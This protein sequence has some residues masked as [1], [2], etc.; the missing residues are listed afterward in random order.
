MAQTGTSVNIFSSAGQVRWGV[1]DSTNITAKREGEVSLTFALNTTID[2]D[3]NVTANDHFYATSFTY[4]GYQE[5]PLT[6]WE[7]VTGLSSTSTSLDVV[8]SLYTGTFNKRITHLNLYRSSSTGAS[9]TPTGFFRLIKSISLKAGWLATDTNTTN[10]DWG[11]YH[12]KTIVDTGVSYASYESR[13]GISEAILKTIPNYGLSTKVNNFLFIADCSHIDIDNA[14]NY[15]FKSRPFSFDQF[16][17]ARDYLLLP[18]TPVALATFNGRV[19]AFSE[20][21]I[22][23][24]NPDGMYIEDTLEGMGCLHQNAVK[25]TDIGMCF[26]DKNSVYFHDGRQVKDIGAR[27]RSAHQY[28]YARANFTSLETLGIFDTG[29]DTSG[30]LAYTGEIVMSYDAFRKAFYIHFTTK[31]W[32]T[33]AYYYIA[34]ANIYTVPKDRWD[35]WVRQHASGGDSNLTVY[36]STNG[37][38]GE[39]LTSDNESG[40]IQPFDPFSSTRVADITWFS[41]KFTMGDDTV[42]KKF[43]KYEALS[44]DSTPSLA[45]NTLED[46]TNA[47]TTLTTARQGRHIQLKLTTNDTTA[48]IDALRVVYRKLRRAK[49]M[50]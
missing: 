31:I 30:K 29:F 47:Y 20:S 25:A 22:Y 1:S 40:L 11:D 32:I 13:T 34:F 36:G 46:D 12:T 9:V 48:T 2:G 39:V 7:I 41:K 17:W 3:L 33:S 35:V 15:I 21:N 43:Y 49:A 23:V 16:N 8:I 6:P 44:A 24:I 5:S 27:I 45:V 26:M 14:A 37:K 38:N 10:P 4:D 50:T 28:E 42:D 18:T 19:Y